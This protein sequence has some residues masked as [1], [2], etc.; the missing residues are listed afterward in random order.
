MA[1]AGLCNHNSQEGLYT[2]VTDFVLP[3]DV[4]GRER[5]DNGG[6][7][8]KCEQMIRKFAKEISQH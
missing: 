8:G 1:H 7:D 6:V 5:D 4:I 3:Y 2:I